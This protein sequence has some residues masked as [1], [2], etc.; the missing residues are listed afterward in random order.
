[1]KKQKH[2]KNPTYMPYCL[3]AT[4]ESLK[5]CALLPAERGGKSVLGLTILRLRKR[6]LE[7]RPAY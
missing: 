5:K 4:E 7:F 3:S 1:M 6:L 2:K